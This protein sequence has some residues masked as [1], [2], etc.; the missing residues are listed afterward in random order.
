MDIIY[1]NFSLIKM[2]NNNFS[3]TS[4][5]RNNKIDL[6]KLSKEENW[7]EIRKARTTIAI[8]SLKKSLLRISKE[9]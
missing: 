7:S 2:I 8:T 6:I 9:K 5:E 4:Q 3:D 1:Y